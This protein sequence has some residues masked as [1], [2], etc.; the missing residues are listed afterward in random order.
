MSHDPINKLV[1]EWFFAGISTLLSEGSNVIAE[2]AFQHHVW[3]PQFEVLASQAEI[4]LIICDVPGDVA[5]RRVE[6]RFCDEPGRA[7]VHPL[8]ANHRGASEPFVAPNMPFPTLIVDTSDGYLPSL[9][10]VIE[11]ARPVRQFG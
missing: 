3:T 5:F 2:A 6:A 10:A 8:P 11:F 9:E 1:F 4:R 7:T